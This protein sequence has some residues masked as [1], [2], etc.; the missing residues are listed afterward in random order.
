MDLNS[1]LESPL[2]KYTGLEEKLDDFLKK[3]MEVVDLKHIVEVDALRNGYSSEFNKFV[4]ANGLN[5]KR[6]FPYRDNDSTFFRLYFTIPFVMSELLDG[7]KCKYVTASAIAHYASINVQDVYK[8]L[9]ELAAEGL[10]KK[11]EI[12][13]I[14]GHK[15]IK[16]EKDDLKKLNKTSL[17]KI[18]NFDR[19]W[20]K[21][22]EQLRKSYEKNY[23]ELLENLKREASRS[24]SP[25][26]EELLSRSKPQFY[27]ALTDLGK[28]RLEEIKKSSPDI[29]GKFQDI[30]ETIREK[31][32]KLASKPFL[33]LLKIL[34]IKEREIENTYSIYKSVLEEMLKLPDGSSY[35]CPLH[36]C[37]FGKYKLVCVPERP[38]SKED[39]IADLYLSNGELLASLNAEIPLLVKIGSS[40]RD[41]KEYE[42]YNFDLRRKYDLICKDIRNGVVNFNANGRKIIYGENDGRTFYTNGNVEKVILKSQKEIPLSGFA[43]IVFLTEG[44]DYI[45]KSKV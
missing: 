6:K 31:M 38:K 8:C 14:P 2:D 20:K 15:E 1:K 3:R 18:E 36:F 19:A 22:P 17:K 23:V 27:Y 30:F 44:W 5:E 13:E 24:L 7:S 32:D 40:S 26:K 29:V 28:Q 9:N 35:L 33:E 39:K 12:S 21:L 42:R 34:H 37:D 41:T 10:V 43:G 4:N 25:E 11:L 45:L 16:K